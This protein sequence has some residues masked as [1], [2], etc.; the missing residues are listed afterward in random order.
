MVRLAVFVD[1]Q[2]LRNSLQEFKFQIDPRK[3]PFRLDEKHFAWN[4]FFALAVKKVE[5]EIGFTHKLLRVC[6]F[7]ADG[8]PGG[9]L[10]EHPTDKVRKIAESLGVSPED[11]LQKAR[12][13]YEKQRKMMERARE[14]YKEIELKTKFVEFR[15][16]GHLAVYPLEPWHEGT[17]IEEGRVVRYSGT[18]RG[19]KGVDVGMAVEMVAKMPL[20]DAAMI[21]SGDVDFLPAVRI[22]RANMK[23]TY[24][25]SLAVGVPPR[26][27]YLSPT[28]K[29][30]VDLFVYLDEHE[31]LSCCDLKAVRRNHPLVA[32]MVQK[33]RAELRKQKSL[34]D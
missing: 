23:W 29:T 26:I 19:E 16:V 13:W 20:Y 28:L 7:N 4:K 18:R 33:R 21:V 31:V 8:I 14:I 5:A 25:L 30:H 10:P 11:L 9:L 24:Q 12:E 32:E 17:V 15:Y 34:E 6:W 27:R 1:G 2:N 3:S 22:L